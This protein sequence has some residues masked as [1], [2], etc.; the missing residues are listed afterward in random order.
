MK[1]PEQSRFVIY[2]LGIFL[3]YFLYGIVQEKITRGRYGTEVNEDGSIGAR[4]TYALALVWVQ[5]FC[6]FIFAKG[7]LT[8][9]PQKEDTTHI[10]Y[11]VISALTYL[12]AMVSSNMALRWVPYPTQVVGKAAKPIPVMILGVLIGRKSYSWIRYTCVFT[13]VVGV[14]LFMYNESK[15]SNTPAEKTGL[16]ELLLFLSLS[17]DGLLGAV[18]ER[19]RASSSPSGQQMML[20]MNFWSTL[21]LGFA[22]IVTGEGKE[23]VYFAT[24]HPELCIHLAMLALC[25]ALGQLFIFLMV[26]GFGPLACSVVT[27]TR[28]FFTVLCSV[29]LFGNVLIARQWFGA[30]LVF[31]GLFADMIYGK[32]TINNKKSVANKEKET[33][34]KKKLIS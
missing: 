10:G 15:I 5:C 26:A 14:I 6:N 25:G 21:M 2:A 24:C 19:M 12:L 11:Y 7:M 22:M 13:I 28:K 32:K 30:V 16:G 1:L 23:F 33:E 4:F 31:A 8:V 18:Q 3:C 34:E 17:M 27:T 20:A 9:K 29:L